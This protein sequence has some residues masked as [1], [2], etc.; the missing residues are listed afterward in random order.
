MHP[1]GCG[2]GFSYAELLPGQ[3]ELKNNRISTCI[4]QIYLIFDVAVW[5]LSSPYG[6]YFLTLIKSR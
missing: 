5:A 3:R 4:A 2:L 6:D 1:H